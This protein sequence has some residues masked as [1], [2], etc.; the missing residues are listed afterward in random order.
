MSNRWLCDRWWEFREGLDYRWFRLYRW[1]CGLRGHK[2]SEWQ[3]IWVGKPVYAA[4]ERHCRRCY[5][6]ERALES[7]ELA[8]NRKG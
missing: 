1:L 4:W 6:I 5:A 8:S 2:Y 7:P 3:R